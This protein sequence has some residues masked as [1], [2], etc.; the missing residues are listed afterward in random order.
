MTKQRTVHHDHCR[1]VF[2]SIQ[3][4]ILPTHHLP[5]NLEF[6]TDAVFEPSTRILISL[7]LLL[8]HYKDLHAKALKEQHQDAIQE[9]KQ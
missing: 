7:K 8:N 4:H 6:L 9:R 3:Q 1:H 2:M 5:S